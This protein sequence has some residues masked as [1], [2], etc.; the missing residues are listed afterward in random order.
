MIVFSFLTDII[1]Q[2]Y[3]T[4]QANPHQWVFNL[5][6]L[7]LKNW[8]VIGIDFSNLETSSHGRIKSSSFEIP[9]SVFYL[10]SMKINTK[11]S[12]KIIRIIP[13][14]GTSSQTPNPDYLTIVTLSNNSLNKR[15]TKMKLIRSNKNTLTSLSLPSKDSSRK[16]SFLSQKNLKLLQGKS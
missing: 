2:W 10:I 6:W 7:I 16:D 4:V 9:L 11:S 12:V 13:T 3:P 8:Y 1:L 14:S 15:N 5:R